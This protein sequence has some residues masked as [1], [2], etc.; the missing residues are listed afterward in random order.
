MGTESKCFNS[1]TSE[2]DYILDER[3]RELCLEEQRSI[4]LCRLGKFV[5]RL[6]L[7]NPYSA[8]FALPHHELMPIPLNTIQ[9]NLGAVMLQNPG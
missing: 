2:I 6:K 1:S 3:A 7:Y 8:P 5:S 9:A 4:T